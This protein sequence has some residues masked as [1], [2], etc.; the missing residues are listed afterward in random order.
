MTET[1]PN[2]HGVLREKIDWHPTVEYELCI[3]CGICV[4]GC[5]T[6][7]YAFDFDKNK[8]LVVAHLKCKVGCV[9]C[10][11]TCPAHAI[12]FP[13]LSYLHKIIKKENVL[14]T[15]RNELKNSK[16]KVGYQKV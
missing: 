4:L 14:T 11:N 15:S 13:P 5:G 8:P 10:A 6:N 9:T 7:V 3:G 16:D 1:K 2:W 12:S